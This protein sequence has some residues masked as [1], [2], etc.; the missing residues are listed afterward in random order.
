MSLS[1]TPAVYTLRLV[2]LILD[3]EKETWLIQNVQS[4]VLH[5]AVETGE[6]DDMQSTGSKRPD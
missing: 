5:A 2:L 4:F 6:R 3:I 1:S